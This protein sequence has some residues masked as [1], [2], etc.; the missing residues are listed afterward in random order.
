MIPDSWH[1]LPEDSD[2]LKLIQRIFAQLQLDAISKKE[3]IGKRDLKED[4]SNKGP[5]FVSYKGKFTDLTQTQKKK[6]QKFFSSLN[7]N[8]QKQLTSI[9]EDTYKTLQNDLKDEIYKREKEEA[10][11]K[12]DDLV[13]KR[14]G[15]VGFVIGG[16][17]ASLQ[18]YVTLQLYREDAS[19]NNLISLAGAV[20]VLA[21]T[22]FGLPRAINP[23]VHISVRVSGWSCWQVCYKVKGLSTDE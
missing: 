17:G 16:V 9:S 8:E 15:T 20:L 4:D 10:K 23:M 22:L 13:D 2:A 3:Y 5:F 6:V 21:F 1:D 7:A 11:Q 12:Q 18:S 19:L 14:V